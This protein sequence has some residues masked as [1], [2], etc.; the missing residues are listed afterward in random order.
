M[1]DDHV[2]R[3]DTG[4]LD[5]PFVARRIPGGV[6]GPGG[7]DDSIAIADVDGL[8]TA[9]NGK[10]ATNH[11]HEIANVTGLQTALDGKAGTSHT[12]SIANVTGLQAALDGKAGTS[13]THSIANVTGLQAALDGKAGTSHTHTPASLGAAEVLA[14]GWPG[15][16]R[17]VS[18]GTTWHVPAT[19]LVSTPT[20]ISANSGSGEIIVEWTNAGADSFDIYRATTSSFVDAVLLQ[21]VV[22]ASYTDNTPTVGVTYYYWVIGRIGAGFS[23]PPE[24]RFT[25]AT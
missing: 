24:P 11:T 23:E 12:H 4:V 3:R 1:P 19:S 8:Q 18:G 15:F 16:V 14:S 25:A 10:A 17:L 2:F 6:S 22:G 21:N 9:L 5:G 7:E 13:H 20:G